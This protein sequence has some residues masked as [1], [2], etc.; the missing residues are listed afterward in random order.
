MSI[1]PWI[2]AAKL[3]RA[4]NPGILRVAPNIKY[5]KDRGKEPYRDPKEFPWF[6]GSSD[7]VNDVNL[8]I[9]EKRKAR[10]LA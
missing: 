2:T 5:T 7:R 3:Y 9:A 1:R 10:G 4:K 6:P 8:T